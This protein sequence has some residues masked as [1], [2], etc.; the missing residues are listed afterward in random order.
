[1]QT[2]CLNVGILLLPADHPCNL[3]EKGP[4]LRKCERGKVGMK[5]ALLQGRAYFKRIEQDVIWSGFS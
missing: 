5:M 2:T 4:D 1:V 3:G